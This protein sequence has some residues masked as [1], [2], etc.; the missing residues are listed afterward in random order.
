MTA[1]LSPL[2]AVL[3]RVLGGTAVLLVLGALVFV[4][5]ARLRASYGHLRDRVGETW[6][7]LVLLL[8]VLGVNK[9]A[10]DVGPEVSWAIGWNITGVIY[11]VEGEFVALV[12]SLASPPLTAFFAFV[13]L[14]GYVF[15]LVFPFVA[16]L[17]LPDQRFLKAT[18]VAYALNYAV[19][20][21]CYVLFVSYGPRNLL[22]GQVES[23]LYVTYPRTQ[24]LTGAVN[25]NTNVFP[26]LHTSLSVTVA[27]LAVQ[28][29]ERYPG[30]SVLAAP[31][32]AAVAFA[33]MYLGIHWALDVVAGILLGV[34]STAAG[35][36]VVDRSYEWS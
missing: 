35:L 32:A 7:Y 22:P 16:Y 28:S 30:W 25:V 23:L 18:S 24:I 31:L 10:R 11:A 1:E 4:G 2:A 33:T 20:V 26:S 36:A 34:G 5:P 27:A 8:A 3:L 29:R 15:L 6:P 19:G 21:A 17:A 12:Q 9:V 13:Y 14:V